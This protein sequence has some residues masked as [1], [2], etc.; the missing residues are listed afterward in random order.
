MKKFIIMTRGR[1]GSTAIIDELS[2]VKGVCSAAHE[3]ILKMDFSELLMKY[4]MLIKNYG[5]MIPFELWK[6]KSPWWRRIQRCL[7]DD[8]ELI[9]RYLEEVETFALR[10][11]A[12]AFGFKVL[13]NHFMETTIL[14]EILLERGYC[15]IYLK[16]NI[17]H[18][19]ISGLIANLRGVYSTDSEYLD[20][21]SY[22]IDIEEFH[23]LVKWETQEVENDITFLATAGFKFIE[24]SY[25]EYMKNRQ[26]FF[27]RVLGFLGVQ[28]ELPPASSYRVLIKDIKHT[29]GN[30]QAVADCAVAM[31][32]SIE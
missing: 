13:S 2:K 19:V 24:V 6:T 11:G 15:A 20:D 3:L 29:I 25:E 4:P 30:Y 28:A 27:N 9:R 8:N 22:Q 23:N 10:E 5:S 26:E 17:P 14:K 31:G 32:M 21:N 7:L 1:T 12:S 18:Q 16:R